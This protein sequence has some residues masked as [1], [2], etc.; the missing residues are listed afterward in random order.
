[1][2]SIDA[3]CGINPI[4]ARRPVDKSQR[5]RLTQAEISHT[6]SPAKQNLASRL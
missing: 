5:A 3:E 1:M 6:E 2:E 4:F